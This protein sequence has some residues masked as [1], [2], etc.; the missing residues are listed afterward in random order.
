M[1][2]TKPSK[3]LLS[4]TCHEKS[5]RKGGFQHIGSHLY[6][7]DRQNTEKDVSPALSEDL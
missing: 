6:L 7:E 5:N 1:Y 4:Q 3:E 2:S